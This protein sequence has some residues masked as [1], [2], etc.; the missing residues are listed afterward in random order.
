[1]ETTLA[2]RDTQEEGKPIL[3]AWKESKLQTRENTLLKLSE[4]NG[5]QNKRQCYRHDSA[6][7]SQK[8]DHAGIQFPFSS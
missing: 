8:A 7:F 5:Q 6:F 4:F 1:M 2:N 3:S